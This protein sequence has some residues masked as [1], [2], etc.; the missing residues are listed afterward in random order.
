VWGRSSTGGVDALRLELVHRPLGHALLDRLLVD[1]AETERPQR[2]GA[3][4][5][6]VRVQSY[7][8]VAR[9]IDAGD[10]IPERR[11]IPTV[12]REEAL[13]AEGS[14]RLAGR[15]RHALEVVPGA[16]RVELGDRER[17]HADRGG[18]DPGHVE[19]GREHPRVADELELVQ[20]GGLAG[21]E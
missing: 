14:R 17:G 19:D 21:E 20:H 8:S 12:G 7:P 10:R 3:V 16:G 2:R 1:V 9:G 18:R 4:V 5:R 6:V 13:A 11:Q 15:H